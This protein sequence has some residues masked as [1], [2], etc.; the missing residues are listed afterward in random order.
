LTLP[1]FSCLATPT[2][3]QELPLRCWR[4]TL[5]PTLT[6]LMVAVMAALAELALAVPRPCW[7]IWGS[8][9][10]EMRWEAAF[11][12]DDVS[13]E[14]AESVAEPDSVVMSRD[15]GISSARALPASTRRADM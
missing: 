12:T 15:A 7:T 10:S 9:S 2:F 13:A 14:A 1:F 6:G 11:S 3:F 5:R 4:M 8:A